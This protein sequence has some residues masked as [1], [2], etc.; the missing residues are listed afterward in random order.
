MITFL[1]MG[2]FRMLRVHFGCLI[3]LVSFTGC[4]G[5]VS[6]VQGTVTIDGELAPRG[7]VVFHPVAG[8][9][10]AY[11]TINKDGSY[12]LR[13]GQGDLSD[14]DAGEIEAGEYIVTVVV[15]MPSQRDETVEES[16]PPHPGARMT[17][18]KYASKDTSDLRA[19]VKAGSNVVPLE[20]EAATAEETAAPPEDT[21]SPTEAP[22]TPD[23][24]SNQNEEATQPVPADSQTPPTPEPDT[25]KAPETEVPANGSDSDEPPQEQNQ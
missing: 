6:N 14:P 10:T 11:G 17:A 3:A 9:P 19:T 21:Q 24:N 23:S 15:N 20:L 7:T 12:A 4:G 18:S 2:D 16:E 1:S 22:P 25:A 8:G 5:P 13:V